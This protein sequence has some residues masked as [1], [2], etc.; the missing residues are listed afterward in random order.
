MSR[1]VTDEAV[2]Q[3]QRDATTV[4]TVCGTAPTTGQQLDYRA[5]AGVPAGRLHRIRRK[6]QGRSVIGH[7]PPTSMRSAARTPTGTSP[8]RW[9]PA[10]HRQPGESAGTLLVIGALALLAVRR[11]GR[12]GVLPGPAAGPP[13]AGP[14]QD[15]RPARLRRRPAARAAATGVP[16]LDRVAEGLDGSARSGSADLLTAEREFAAGRL[17]P[18]ADPAD[19]AVHAA[20]GDHRRRRRPGRGPGGGRRP[21]SARPSGSPTWS[22]SCSTGPAA[23][24][25]DRARVRPST[26][27]LAQQVAEWEPAFRRAN[28]KLEVAGEQGPARGTPRPATLAQVIATLMDN[29]LVH[30]AGTVTIRTSQTPQLGGGRGARRGPRGAAGAGPADLRAQRQRPPA[31]APGSAWPW[32][33]RWPRPTAAGWCWSGE[34]RRSS[35]LP[36]AGRARRRR[37]TPGGQRPGVRLRGADDDLAAPAVKSVRFPRGPSGV[38]G[39]RPG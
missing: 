8:S 27:I 12:A 20:G 24:G 2:R 5:F 10:L 32:P 29:A 13:A 39:Q 31:T 37:G 15:R 4:A 28:R 18:A 35:P 1:L 30:G 38:S 34:A 6:G 26:T 11:G 22:A 25:S 14:G 17:A 23:V 9:R 19:R 16:E 21:R 7:P 33:G 3:L 36:A